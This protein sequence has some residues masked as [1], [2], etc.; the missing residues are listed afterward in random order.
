MKTIITLV[1]VLEAEKE[2]LD[3]LSGILKNEH[4]AIISNDF[5]LITDSL[6]QK[7]EVVAKLKKLENERR[8]F[9]VSLSQISGVQ[10]DELRMASLIEMA[11]EPYATRLKVSWDGLNNV[12]VRVRELGN[13]NMKLLGKMLDLVK[14]SLALLENM[15]GAGPVYRRTGKLHGHQSTGKV[16]CESI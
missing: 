8:R 15:T 2:I 12:M 10:N 7:E 4:K 5:N 1:S 11:Q 13:K 14:N 9:C 3:E 6:N 16:L